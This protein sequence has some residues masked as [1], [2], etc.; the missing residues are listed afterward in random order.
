L[1]YAEKKSITLQSGDINLLQAKK[2]KLAAIF[3]IPDPVVNKSFTFMDNTKLPVNLFP[4]EIF[5]GQASTFKEVQMGLQYNSVINQHVDIKL[6]NV[7]G[8]QNLKLAKINIEVNEKNNQLTRKNLYENIAS[9]YYNIVQLQAQLQATRQNLLLSDTL[10]QTAQHKYSQGLVKKQDVND[11]KVN[12]LATAENVKQIEYLISQNYLSLKMLVDIPDRENIII[13]NYENIPGGTPSVEPD[14]LQVQYNISREKYALT[15][16]K[17][18][19]R[20]SLPTLSF[21]LSNSFNQFNQ[22]FTLTGGDWIHSQYIGLKLNFALPNATSIGNRYKAKYDYRL[23]L[24]NTDHARIKADIQQR[25]LGVDYEKAVSQYRNNKEILLLREDTYRK[26][27]NLYTEGLI[28][29]DQ[30]LTSFNNLVNSQ[31]NLITA[32]ISILLANAKISINNKIK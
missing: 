29:L 2:A 15:N 16:F 11:S 28:S 18:L 24:K 25:Q 20:S 8:W 6:L 14:N 7:A 32:E 27:K 5:G 1:C 21:I 23:A 9:A 17:Q 31:Y 19:K 12:M 10:L 26:N 13:S 30:T 4:A 22:D 3:S